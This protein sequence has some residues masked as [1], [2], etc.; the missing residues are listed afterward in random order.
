M[1]VIPQALAKGPVG[2]K[3]KHLQNSYLTQCLAGRP[4]HVVA[5]QFDGYARGTMS[6][7]GPRERGGDMA[8][9]TY[10]FGIDD[11]LGTSDNL[12]VFAKQLGKMDAPL[13]VVLTP[14]L[15]RL[16][17]GHTPDAAAIWNALFAATAEAPGQDLAGPDDDEEAVE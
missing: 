1:V 15:A 10:E 4:D 17:A 2:T 3:H 16:A 6:Y 13:A 5:D 9:K 12:A 11:A 8:K 14:H 7:G